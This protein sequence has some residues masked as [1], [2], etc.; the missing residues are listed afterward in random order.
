VRDFLKED[1][2]GILVSDFYS[3]YNVV[4]MSQRQV[5]LAHLL[6]ELKKVDE[7]NQSEEWQS[8][9]RAIRRLLS[10]A[11]KLG[12]RTDRDAP[13]Y[14]SKRQRLQ[15]RLDELI[16]VEQG[17]ADCRRLQ[18]RLLKH[19][20]S[21]FK[22]LDEPLVPPDNNR[23]EREIRPAVIARKNSFHNMSDAG[24]ETQARMMSIY[25]TL[26]LRGLNPLETLAHALAEY[27]EKG[28]IPPM[29]RAPSP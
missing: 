14:A 11:L 16:A 20:E 17:D 24:A 21:V 26:K 5:C 19:R 27:V 4:E 3:V 15:A 9:R 6:R 10:D 22:F 13:D 23:A 29:P 7:N 28:D 18:K 2:D 25:R 12:A 1:F 8:F